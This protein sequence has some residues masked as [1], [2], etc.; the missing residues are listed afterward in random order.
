MLAGSW[1]M[2]ATAQWAPPTRC[3]QYGGYALDNC[4]DTAAT[5]ADTALNAAYAKA[6]TFI[7]ASDGA[8]ADKTAWH[9]ALRA[10][11]RAWIAYRDANCNADLI[12]AEWNSGSG[13]NAAQKAC[14]L[15]MTL[16]RTD[17]LTKRYTAN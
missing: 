8:A 12:D 3:D 14:V 9:D 13:A 7:D 6:G 1:P 5:A 4:L 17:E 2:S 15:A 11:Q 16:A 10:A